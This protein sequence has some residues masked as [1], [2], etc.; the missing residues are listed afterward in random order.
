MLVMAVG[1]MQRHNFWYRAAII[2]YCNNKINSDVKIKMPFLIFSIT[3]LL[4][5][6]LNG[7]PALYR[8]QFY[9]DFFLCLYAPNLLYVL[10][11]NNK[12]KMLLFFLTVFVTLYIVLYMR[13]TE[14]YYPYKFYWEK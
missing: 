14:D 8:L 12:L 5:P 2:G 7:N 1:F 11:K 9:F 6:I 3:P 4:W 10:P 13:T